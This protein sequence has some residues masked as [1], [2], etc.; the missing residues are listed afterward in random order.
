M[1][2]EQ[3]LTYGLIAAALLALWFLFKVVKKVVFVVL[4]VVAIVGI[5]VGLYLK[6]F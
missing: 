5:L 4:V 1:D 2:G 6:F 3:I